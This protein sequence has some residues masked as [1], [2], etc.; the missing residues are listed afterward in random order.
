MIEVQQ[1]DFVS[2]LIL[3]HAVEEEEDDDD[4]PDSTLGKAFHWVKK[5]LS[6]KMQSASSGGALT[7]HLRSIQGSVRE[8][9]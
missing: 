2:L 1:Y 9:G 8:P 4:A 7:V 5:N 3:C 6:R